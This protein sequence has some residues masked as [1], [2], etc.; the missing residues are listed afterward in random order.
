MNSLYVYFIRILY[1]LTFLSVHYN[2]DSF[3]ARRV[4]NVYLTN[5]LGST[6]GGRGEGNTNKQNSLRLF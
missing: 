2:A 1:V 5:E 6:G 4:D 3:T